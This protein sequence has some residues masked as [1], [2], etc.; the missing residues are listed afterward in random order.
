MKY[1]LTK[2]QVLLKES[3]LISEKAVDWNKS[4]LGILTGA[5]LS[6]LSWL[7]GSIK[8]GIKKSQLNGL[9]IQWGLEYVKALEALDKNID[10]EQTSGA[11]EEDAAETQTTSETPVDDNT[12]KITEE[13]KP[14][15]LASLKKEQAY[16]NSANNAIKEMTTWPTYDNQD[17]YESIKKKLA[18]IPEI[19]THALID[20]VPLMDAK[21][22]D[23]PKHIESVIKFINDIIKFNM[24]DFHKNYK[25]IVPKDAAGRKAVLKDL[26]ITKIADFTGINNACVAAIPF[27]TDFKPEAGPVKAK[28]DFKVGNEYIHTDKKGNKTVVKLISLDY[29]VKAGDDK[30]FLTK[31]DVNEN[32][33]DPKFAFVSLKDKNVGYAVNIKNLSEKANESAMILEAKSFKIPNRVQDLLA[34]DELDYYKQKPD[35]KNL[36]FPKINLKRLDSIKYEAN[37]ILN[38]SKDPKSSEKNADLLRV[39]EMGI[40]NVNDYFQ[41]VIDVDKVMT[42]VKG[43]VDGKVEQ[44]VKDNSAKIDKLQGLGISE[45]VPV[46]TKFNV[47][48]LY[49][50]E[51]T[52]TGQNNKAENTILMMSPTAEFAETIDDKNYYWFKLLGAYDYDLKSSKIVRKNLFT[53]L[54]SNKAITNNFNNVEAAYYAVFTNLRSDPRAFYFEIYSNKGKFFYNGKVIDDVDTVADDIKTYKQDKFVSTRK[55]I[56]SVSNFFKIKI[57]QRFLVD[58]ANIVANKYPGI[59]MADLKTDKGIDAAKANHSKFMAL[60][61]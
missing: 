7:T 41:E 26:L 27:V 57:N 38:K 22:A 42:E 48:K 10:V 28:T 4:A 20:V 40:K 43:V 12:F 3:I 18:D 37:F 8:T 15:L 39:W 6:P 25:I 34:A 30:I 23:T 59:Q 54:T 29:S 44:I 33:L 16:F 51:C 53:N 14:T 56:A 52:I 1:L 21:Y 32:E 61:K 55:Q 45:V 60:L 2:D 31:D 58:D 13:N 19:D 36:T 24:S 49:A 47:N 17:G 50:F 5:I 9:A 11:E 35:I 46:G